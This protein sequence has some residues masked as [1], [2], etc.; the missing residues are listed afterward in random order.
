MRCFGEQC[1][2]DDPQCEGELRGAFWGGTRRP[3]KRE[4]DP[5]CEGSEVL[6]GEQCAEDDP[7]CEGERFGV[8]LS[9]G[10]VVPLSRSSVVP[11]SPKARG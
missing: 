1:A 11:Q 2:E 6:L 8:R 5:Q 7:Q 4:D 10:P 9:R 3:A